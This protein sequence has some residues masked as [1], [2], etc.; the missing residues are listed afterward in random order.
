[1]LVLGDVEDGHDVRGGRDARSR[2]R[3]PAEA[4]PSV[5][6]PGIP[7]GQHLDRDGPLERGIGRAVD[8]THPSASDEVRGGVPPREHVWSDPEVVPVARARYTPSTE[9]KT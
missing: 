4:R 2:E 7:V 9:E 8:L 3:L 1:T 5:V 6:L